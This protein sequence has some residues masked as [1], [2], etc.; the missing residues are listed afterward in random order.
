MTKNDRS[1]AGQLAKAVGYS[2]RTALKEHTKLLDQLRAEPDGDQLIQHVESGDWDISD[3]RP[4]P[5]PGRQVELIA[6]S[7]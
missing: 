3:V 4:I 2:S 6:E 7:G 5:L 1:T